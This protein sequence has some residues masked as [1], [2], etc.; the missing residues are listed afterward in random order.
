LEAERLN[1]ITRTS[2]ETFLKIQMP[3][4]DNFN[5]FL[6]YSNLFELAGCS[7]SRHIYALL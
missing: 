3:S 6:S 2:H 5:S 7:K 1:R 4:L